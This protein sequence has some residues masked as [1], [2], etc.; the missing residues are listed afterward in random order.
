MIPLQTLEQAFLDRLT[1]HF[2]A[3]LAV[4]SYPARTEG[5]KLLHPF[6]AV[7]IAYLGS[8]YSDPLDLGGL[9]QQN[10]TLRWGFVLQTRNRFTHAE[11]LPWLDRL[12]GQLTGFVPQ[13]G[14]S[15]CR[16]TREQFISEDEGI[17]TWELAISFELPLVEDA[18]SE[19]LLAAPYTLLT[20][21]AHGAPV[22]QVT[23]MDGMA[24]IDIETEDG[25]V[26]VIE[27]PREA[28]LCGSE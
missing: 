13:P 28:P 6:G 1:P 27:T 22:Q 20:E 9:M 2:G 11:S 15:R 16:L 17:W 8:D 25:E 21:A 10:R 19:M 18:D 12:R 3:E 4:Q 5:Y 24:Q 14:C 26:T 7:L 23:A